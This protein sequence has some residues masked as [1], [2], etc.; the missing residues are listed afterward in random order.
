MAIH[1]AALR[2][3]K[4]LYI[5]IGCRLFPVELKVLR[6]ER[7]VGM[8]WL[9]SH[10]PDLLMQADVTGFIRHELATSSPNEPSVSF[11]LLSFL[12]VEPLKP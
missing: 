6:L 1:A 2:I 10:I 3:F 9:S 12:M 5:N 11:V 8:L 4:I 7:V